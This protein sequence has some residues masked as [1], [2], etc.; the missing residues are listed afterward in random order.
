MSLEILLF[1]KLMQ[2][3]A[4]SSVEECSKQEINLI[5][6]DTITAILQSP[7]QKGY[8]FL[9]VFTRNQILTFNSALN[10]SNQLKESI[11]FLAKFVNQNSLDFSF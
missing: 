3:Y 6:S 11:D 7:K 10:K 1:L 9:E 4:I 5:N 8:L 2:I